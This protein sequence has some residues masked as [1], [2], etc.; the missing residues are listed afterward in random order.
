MTGIERLRELADKYAELGKDHTTIDVVPSGMAMLFSSIA[1]QIERETM[2]RKPG[3]GIMGPKTLHDMALVLLDDWE[4]DAIA[5]VR[6]RGGLEVVR[7]QLDLWK[8][9]FGW[10]VELGGV[11]TCCEAARW[12]R[13][14]GGLD[15][16]K[17]EWH[18]R[19]PYDRHEKTRQR[20]LDH[21]AECETALGR[22]RRRIKELGRTVEFFQ[23][24]NSNFRHLL[25]DVAERL[26]FTR[27]GDDYEPEDLIDALDRRLMPE[28][29]EWPR[30]EDGEPVRIGDAIVD[31]MGHAHEVSSVEVFDD[32]EALH[33]SP[34]E[35]DDFVWLVHG[36]LVKRPDSKVLDA[37]G[38]EI[39]VGDT[40]W[41]VHDLDKFTVTN[42]N[43]GENLSVSCM[44]EDGKEY[45]CYPNGLTHRAPVL[46]ADG[47]P[48]R[49]GETVWGINGATYRVTG[50][51]DGEVFARH[52]GGSFGAEVESAGG[53]GLYRLRAEQL[54]HKRPV[55]DADGVLIHE[56]DTVYDKGTGD[57][58][59]VDGFSYDG[60]VCTDIDACESDIEILPSQLTHTKPEPPKRCRD[61]AHW[62]KDP[63]ADN[64]G[65][66]WFLYHEYEGQDCYAARRG[67]IGACE[68]FMPSAKALAGVSE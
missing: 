7:E 5:L 23:L 51:H 14:H 43:N 45:C 33:W 2:P 47:R 62:Q 8:N 20:L 4:R 34:S 30:F 44:G 63:T 46:A 10:A 66:C 31:G 16:V 32:A 1:D 68:E 54:T 64:M 9:V 22:R 55:L 59:E 13:K 28:G 24:N 18:S 56:G 37:D 11:D 17:E 58:F 12:V 57:R 40:V 49:D 60:V 42:S 38:A 41:H 27:Y 26:G 19:V 29:M 39:C 52:I 21:I 65:V 15:S 35:P 36:E 25:A 61:C 48:L 6:E 53:S 50:L 3:D 67:D